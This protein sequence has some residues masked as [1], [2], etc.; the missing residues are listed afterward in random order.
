MT[1]SRRRSTPR[2]L[3]VLLA[4]LAGM[5]PAMVVTA[6][7]ASAAAGD[8]SQVSFTLEG[9]RNNGG[10]TLPIG[11][12]FVCPDA[13]YTTGN[14]GKGWNELDLVPFRVTTGVGTQS[15][16]T[17]DY[18]FAI[19]LDYYKDAIGYDLISVA[20]VN[21]AKS[22][23]SCSVSNGP[24]LPASPTT[25]DASIHRLLTV[26]QD[27]GTTCV[28][29]FYGRLAIG[30]HNYNGSSLHANLFNQSLN[31]S[32]IGSREVSI[33]VREILPQSISKTMN[34]VQ[35]A[36][37]DWS[38][39]K[40]SLPLTRSLGDTCDATNTRTNTVQVTVSWNRLGPAPAGQIQVSTVVTATN[41]ASRVITVNVSDDIR[42]GTTVL[43]TLT[44]GDVDVPANSSAVVLSHTFNVPGDT[45]A[46]NDIAT[47]T[48]TDKA[49][50]VAVPGTTTATA[51]ADVVSSGTTT[52]A[53]AVVT[54]TEHL[55]GSAFRF[56]VDSTS[57]ESGT[58]TPAY[59]LPGAFRT[60]DLTWTSGTL[61]GNGS[62]VFNKT[63]DV[64]SATIATGSLSDVAGLTG[65]D[66][67]TRS[68]NASTTL[69]ATAYATAT[70]SK[71]MTQ[72]FA[73]SKSFTFEL[74]SGT[75]PGTDTGTSRVV[76]I[77]A[78]SLGPVSSTAI[79]G[80]DPTLSYYFDEAA[81]APFPAQTTAG[82]SYAL[83]AGDLSSCSATVSV[84]NS[85][86]PATARVQK[87][88]V[89]TGST[90]W[91]FTLTGPNSLSETKSATAGAGYVAF[92]HVL[93]VDG[94]TYTIT[95]TAQSGWDNTGASGGITGTNPRSAT[96]STATH[97]CAI[98]LNL[99]T[100]SG[101]VLSCSFENTQ[102]AHVRLTK[103][104]SGAAIPSGSPYSFS[105]TLTGG[106]DSVNI[107]ATAD[108][109]NGGSIDFGLLKPGSYTLCELTAGAAWS[110]TWALD[111]LAVTPFNPDA[112]AQDLGTRCYTFTLSAGVDRALSVNN[113]PPPGGGQR[114]IGY[115][116]NWNSLKRSATFLARQ[117]A[118]HAIVDDFIGPTGNPGTVN[119]GNV[120]VD[121]VQKAVNILSDASTKYAE[122]GLAAQLLAAKLNVLAGAAPSCTSINS[123]IA[124]ADAML[125]S[126]GWTDANYQTSKIVGANYDNGTYTRAQIVAVHNTLDAYNNGTCP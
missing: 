103:T 87:T 53:T 85:A 28:F 51:S 38:L 25:S 59:S 56:R 6:S 33:P 73:G 109:T 86:A 124:T 23:A 34:A 112:P 99:T 83:V 79:T 12:R 47:A 104:V 13:A 90:S 52:N 105:F 117:H 3:L 100:D 40:T 17:T 91:S 75:A 24:S 32:G 98:V 106:P 63:V 18:T 74:F 46:L 114:T 9:C 19:A 62:V 37:Y 68:A 48:Y 84:L 72:K 58:F 113:I 121:T 4:L 64:T 92:D 125:I 81:T 82:F 69:N 35:G 2:V 70:V 11:G 66:S 44:S 16:A 30:S 71:S 54:D 108:G 65:S 110:S 119:L 126:V 1:G 50:G 5:L 21:A 61:N 111:G 22:D 8:P 97:T 15:G 116:K 43:N 41:P 93:D 45:T 123:V 77:P 107:P 80:L 57:G 10:I 88:T 76:T 7:P 118:T 101:A 78:G 29:D 122:H 36:A 42:S 95:E 94:G 27:K 89:P 55:T 67:L 102:R 26:H 49:T 96:S 20:T 31:T 39:S 14:L 115:W 120:H 60:A